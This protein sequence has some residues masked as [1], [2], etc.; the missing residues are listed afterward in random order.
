MEHETLNLLHRRVSIRKFKPEM[1]DE[2][3][4]TKLLE[5][6][7]AAPSAG[8]LQNY[9]IIQIA[10]PQRK[11]ALNKLCMEQDCVDS[12][13][14]AFI[15]LA[16]TSRFNRYAASQ[17]GSGHFTWLFNYVLHTTDAAIA[18]QNMVIAAEALGLGSVYIGSILNR[19]LDMI[20]FLDL[21]EYVLPA[22]MLSVG[23]PDEKPEPKP[24]HPVEMVLHKETYRHDSLTE[25][26]ELYRERN[27]NFCGRY[28]AHP[29]KNEL[30]Q[31]IGEVNYPKYVSLAHYTEDKMIERG[32]E[33]LKGMKQ[34]KFL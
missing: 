13:P 28:Q 4:L 14:L 22:A 15:F 30:C 9:T 5:A 7:I 8:N 10:D 17:G 23:W 11:K 20:E 29:R 33:M 25:L 12:A 3:T 16:D 27:E 34:A 2:E 24:R 1:P 18:A 21:P 19:M 6:T 26:S 32:S 31:G